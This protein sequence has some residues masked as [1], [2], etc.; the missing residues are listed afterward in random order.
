M[1]GQGCLAMPESAKICH[2]VKPPIGIEP[3]YLWISQRKIDLTDAIQRY[4]NAGM[5]VPV[6]WATEYNEYV[7]GNRGEYNK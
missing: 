1:E 2:G 6:E 5:Y 3:H 7:K 4:I